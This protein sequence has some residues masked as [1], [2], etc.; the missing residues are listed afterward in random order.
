MREAKLV[1]TSMGHSSIYL[2]THTA[3]FYYEKRGWEIV[4]TVE[5]PNVRYS[6]V[7]MTKQIK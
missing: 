1:A 4:G 5:P 3:Q 7:V 6:S 2:F